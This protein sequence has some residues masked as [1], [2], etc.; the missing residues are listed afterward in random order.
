MKKLT[1]AA[2]GLLLLETQGM[3]APSPAEQTD[4]PALPVAMPIE[5]YTN[6]I[7]HPPFALASQAAPQPAVVDAAGFA[8]D[9]VLT[10]AVR[11]QSGEYITFAS[12][13]QTQ[14]FGLKT[15]ET[16]NGIAVVSVAWSDVIGK[17]KVT[18]KRG[19]E[20][21]V[22][23]FDEA[24]ARAAPPGEGAQPPGTI[25]PAMPAGVTTPIMTPNANPA[26]GNNPPPAV[27]MRRRVIR[28]VPS[29]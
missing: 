5:R 11:L 10:G 17:T 4:S 29:S 28:T 23:C 16:S 8:K 21:G 20:F 12:R 18:L 25:Q 9:L 19:N 26:P 13:D 3:A 14:R 27:P 6:M 1:H 15:G 22:I 24:A 2:L 7:E